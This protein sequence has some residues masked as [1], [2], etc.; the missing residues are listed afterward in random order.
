MALP[1]PPKPKLGEHVVTST[2]TKKKPTKPRN[3]KGGIYDDTPD[4][5]KAAKDKAKAAKDKAAAAAADA[6]DDAA[7]KAAAAKQAEAGR[8]DA[9]ATLTMMLDQWGLGSLTGVV[10]GMVQKDYSTNQIL[11]ELRKSEPYKKRFSGN[12]KRIKAGYA[13]L[14][15]GEYL[16]VEDAYQR[17]L[18]AAGMPKG[19]YDDPADFA[20]WIGNNVSA[21]E[22]SE[23]VNMATN[24]ALNSA[25]EDLEAL[26][27][28]GLNTGDLAASFLDQQ[29]SLPIL[30][31]IVGSAKLGAASL[32]AGLGMNKERAEKYYALLAD[33]NGG[34]DSQFATQA[35]SQV[36]AALPRANQLSRKYG[37]QVDQEV[38]EDEALGRNELASQKRKRL[39]R[40]EMAQYQGSGGL[41]DKGLGGGSR[42]EY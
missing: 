1:T 11:L 23:R 12:E 29:R 9:M 38:L 2:V 3:G 33:A 31:K 28:M 41:G 22:I 15:P 37:E 8:Q 19:F 21:T 7:D 4:N 25:P 36:A 17:I 13:A 10:L 18:Q 20:D 32:K 5:T 42:G 24:A 27:R 6:A 30:N 35:Y 14:E 16:Q 39:G 26:G 40:L 34:I